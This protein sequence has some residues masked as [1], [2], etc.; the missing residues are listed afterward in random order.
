MR[1]GHFDGLDVLRER[2]FGFTPDFV[3]RRA[4]LTSARLHEIER[5]ASVSVFEAESLAEVYGL[6]DADILVDRPIKLSMADALTVLADHAAFK[7]LSQD[8]RGRLLHVARAARDAAALKT[9]LGIDVVAVSEGG[10]EFPLSATPTERRSEVAPL[11]ALA[12]S[13]SLISRDRFA[14]LLGTTP[15]DEI[16]R[17]LDFYR[18]ERPL[19]D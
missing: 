6:D 4:G 10:G 13:R 7:Q 12:Y 16:E 19:G 9:L 2:H 8:E 5:G 3:A 11:A 15:A 18:F 1:S 17:V 14:R